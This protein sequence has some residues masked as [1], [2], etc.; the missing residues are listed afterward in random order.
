VVFFF[1]I[2]VF[3][4][5]V[6]DKVSI[7][8]LSGRVWRRTLQT[9]CWARQVVKETGLGGV[10]RRLLQFVL[11]WNASYT[12]LSKRYFSRPIYFGIQFLC[13]LSRR[14]LKLTCTLPPLCDG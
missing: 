2:F 8:R 4:V 1:F 11:W 9:M 7:S 14:H 12:I 3:F 10:A 5:V 13:G 6:G